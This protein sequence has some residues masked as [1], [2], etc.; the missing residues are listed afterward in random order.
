MHSQQCLLD[1]SRVANER[2]TVEGFVEGM[3]ALYGDRENPHTLR[4][5]ARGEMADLA[6]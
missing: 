4:I 1:F 6:T 2:D 5:S 3:L